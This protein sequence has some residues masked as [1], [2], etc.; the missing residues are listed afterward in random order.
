[1]PDCQCGIPPEIT[2]TANAFPLCHHSDPGK[3]REIQ[4]KLFELLDGFAQNIPVQD[5]FSKPLNEV[6]ET[7]MRGVVGTDY[8]VLNEQEHNILMVSFL[9]HA[10]LAMLVMQVSMILN[11]RQ[12]EQT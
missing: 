7:Y 2:A 12:K 4:Q 11:I 8:N 5:L 3:T 10:A 9:R 1:M 6:A